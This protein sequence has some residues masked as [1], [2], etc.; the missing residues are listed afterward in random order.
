MPGSGGWWGWEDRRRRSA[1]SRRGGGFRCP[2]SRG[3][4][5]LAPSAAAGKSSSSGE[6]SNIARQASMSARAWGSQITT[7]P[8]RLR[9]CPAALPMR[10]SRFP[11]CTRLL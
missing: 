7:N 11:Y 10:Q 1:G 4:W 8:F 3:G 5:G 2:Q 6:T 9:S